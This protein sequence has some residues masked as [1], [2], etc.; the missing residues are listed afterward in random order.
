[1]V[2]ALFRKVAQ[3]LPGLRSDFWSISDQSRSP[4]LCLLTSSNVDLNVPGPLSK[5]VFFN[6]QILEKFSWKNVLQTF[7]KRRLQHELDTHRLVLLTEHYARRSEGAPH[8][9]EQITCMYIY[10]LQGDVASSECFINVKFIVPVGMRMD[11]AQLAS[12]G[13]EMQEMDFDVRSHP[14]SLCAT[15]A[16]PPQDIH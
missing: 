8:S 4:Q 16:V 9:C 5:T 15:N 7:D 3:C 14:S 13:E 10:F 6:L 2:F 1:M 11:E 12:I